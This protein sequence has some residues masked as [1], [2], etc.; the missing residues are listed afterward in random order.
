MIQIK[1]FKENN[2]IKEVSLKGH[3]M[4]D[5]YGKDI[6]C[7]G[8]S[9]ILTTTVN[10]IESI[11]PNSVSYEQK[12]DYFI[13]K[14]NS[15]DEITQKLIQNMINLFDELQTK[16]QKNIKLESEDSCQ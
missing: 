4:Y 10:G 3:A 13:L 11:Q 1:V 6:V 16:Y 9:G 2:I 8:V 12:K 14:I 15:S 7:A 5:D